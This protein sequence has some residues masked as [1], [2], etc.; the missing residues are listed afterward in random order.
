MVGKQSCRPPFPLPS[1]MHPLPL[2]HSPPPPSLLSSLQLQNA[3]LMSPYIITTTVVLFVYVRV[4]LPNFCI[5]VEYMRAV[6]DTGSNSGHAL[7]RGLPA[8]GLV[9]VE[10]PVG[11]VI[12]TPN[13][14][15]AC[16]STLRLECGWCYVLQFG[17]APTL[18]QRSSQ[19][20]RR[21]TNLSYVP[22]THWGRAATRP[23]KSASP[24]AC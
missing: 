9:V 16:P 11:F 1:R 10:S 17:C 13:R 4:Y 6:L 21:G 15:H 23:N 22:P 19:N 20:M 3:D 24:F 12:V 8:Y 2:V 5:L 7:S 14:P 18:R